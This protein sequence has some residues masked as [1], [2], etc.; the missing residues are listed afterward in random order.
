MVSDC[1]G[2]PG[3]MRKG[4]DAIWPANPQILTLWP[5]KNVFSDLQFYVLFSRTLTT[6][7]A[8]RLKQWVFIFQHFCGSET[9]GYLSWIIL[10]HSLSWGC[11]QAAGPDCSHLKVFLELKNPSSSSCRW[12]LTDLSSSPA[13]G[14]EASVPS[15]ELLQWPTPQDSGFVQSKGWETENK[16]E[17]ALFS[18]P[19][20]FPIPNLFNF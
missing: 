18:M 8:D 12:L 13:V 17:S 6:P 16:M 15:W 11:S 5:F 7:K 10:A 19:V 3:R 2:Y 20:E 9:F 14:L 4:T 1:S